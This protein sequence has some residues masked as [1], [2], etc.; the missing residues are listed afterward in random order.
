LG[1]DLINGR[2]F[3][4]AFLQ[5]GIAET[6]QWA[7]LD[8]SKIDKAMAA[9][10]SMVDKLVV[11]KNVNEAQTEKGL[12]YPL[13]DLIGWDGHCFVQ[14]NMAAKGR[15]NIPDALYFL[16]EA[17]ADAARQRNKDI[18]RFDGAAVLVEAKKWER[19]LDRSAQSKGDKEGVPSSQILR[20]LRRADDITNGDLRWGILTNGRIWRLYWQGALSVT[21]D[22]FEIDLALALGMPGLQDDLLSPKRPDHLSNYAWARHVFKLFVL[23]FGRD[24]FAPTNQGRTFHQLAIEEGRFW[25]KRVADSLSEAVFG[26]VYPRL[27]AALGQV[28]QTAE[29]SE[30]RQAALILLYRLLFVLYAE[31][32]NLLPDENGPYAE[33]CLTKTRLEIAEKRTKGSVFPSAATGIWTKLTDIFGFIAI[34]SDQL[35]IPPY[36]GGLFETAAAPLLSRVRLSDCD[37]AEVIFGLSHFDDRK[38]AR[39]PQYINYRDLS[40]QQLGAVYE[41]ILE[42]DLTRNA[43]GEVE[44]IIDD[45]ARH[46]SGSYY[47][48]DDLVKLVIERTVGPCV[49]SAGS[50]FAQTAQ[51]LQSDTR[52]KDERLAQ[53]R[54]CDIASKLLDL[55]VCDPAMGSGHFLVNLVDWLSWRVLDAM[56]EANDLVDWAE[57]V[58]PLAKRIADVREKFFL[59][60]EREIGLLSKLS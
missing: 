31:D 50:T 54:Q 27:V 8:D 10:R 46:T 57:Y 13:M 19:P 14:P 11:Q 26:S 35:G 21:E 43:D 9:A 59:R 60:L 3:T 18:N 23:I 15:S 51:S 52:A 20:Y 32:R 7:S 47:T 56:E 36:N 40:V 4:L 58:S 1:N 25:E 6:P 42:F 55:K 17:S 39:G 49:S 33:Y 5:E 24:A 22:F 41:R 30:I 28:D 45:K 12:I 34:G 44:V 48:S 2:L 53:L 16:D 29:L 37:M 38:D